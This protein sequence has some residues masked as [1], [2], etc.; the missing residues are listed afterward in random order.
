MTTPAFESNDDRLT[1]YA[2][3]ELD[4]AGRAEIEGLLAASP[5][6]QAEFAELQS[7]AK[8]L[9]SELV[10]ESK[11]SLTTEQH[12]ALLKAVIT[13]RTAP[14]S[15]DAC[16][17]QRVR[18]WAIL[19]AEIA[20]GVA[21]AVGI[22]DYSFGPPV[23]DDAVAM[24]EDGPKTLSELA[25]KDEFSGFRVG[26]SNR[27][28]LSDRFYD[29]PLST[30]SNNS[31]AEN[32]VLPEL[33]TEADPKPVSQPG[34]LADPKNVS[35]F[36]MKIANS[37]YFDSEGATKTEQRGIS[38][39]F[40][41]RP[42]DRSSAVGDVSKPDPQ[43]AKPSKPGPKMIEAA[44]SAPEKKKVMVSTDQL[45]RESKPD[46]SKPVT[47]EYRNKD[48]NGFKS[49]DGLTDLSDEYRRRPAN[50][51]TEG[52]AESKSSEF[53]LAKNPSGSLLEDQRQRIRL[54]TEKLRN[55]VTNSIEETRRASDPK[56]EL[57]RLKRTLLTV[58]SATDLAPEDRQRL[59]KL[60]KSEISLYE[61]DATSAEAYEAPPENAFL[62]P[63]ELTLKVWGAYAGDS[64]G[65]R[66]LDA[67][68]THIRRVAPSGTPVSALEMHASGAGAPYRIP[69]I[70]P[71]IDRIILAMPPFCI[72][73]II[74]C[75]CSNCFSRR[76]TS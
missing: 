38:K 50:G 35:T 43:K 56:F 61:K 72:C 15:P 65:A 76:F 40:G 5:E 69:G 36:K 8:M 13:P 34:D 67:I 75:I 1:A 17:R 14:A 3:G 63:F 2:L 41:S 42:D 39:G 46:A 51:R 52:E 62:T 60:L 19:G 73:F 26:N 21:V 54:Q 55:E 59:Q 68:A 18:R 53:S 49:V 4:D 57:G 10:S 29:R 27:E 71:F 45:G 58:A 20:I 47:F 28:R 12:Q 11:P 24:S 33:V 32:T 64:L 48:I 9:R 16:R 7:L 25:R 22:L 6:L 66:V 31:S 30:V 37:G 74:F 44:D 70:I 23:P